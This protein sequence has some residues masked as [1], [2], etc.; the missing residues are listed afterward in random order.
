MPGVL[1][2]PFHAVSG[3]GSGTRQAKTRILYRISLEVQNTGLF[4]I[5]GG[6]FAGGDIEVIGKYAGHGI[7][8][9]SS[10]ASRVTRRKEAENAIKSTGC[11]SIFFFFCHPLLRLI[12]HSTVRR[13]GMDEGLTPPLFEPGARVH[14]T[15]DPFCVCH[16]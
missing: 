14:G 5:C 4:V 2:F 8:R 11:D 13:Y 6:M 1:A 16:A 9:G 3:F 10:L 15:L 12:C 7:N